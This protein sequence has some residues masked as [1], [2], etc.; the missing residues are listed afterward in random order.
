ML[1][2]WESFEAQMRALRG[3][4]GREQQIIDELAAVHREEG[5]DGF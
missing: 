4:S 1:A 2:R 3:E 5:G